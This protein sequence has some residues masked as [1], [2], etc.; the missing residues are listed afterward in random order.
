MNTN[1]NPLT[2]YTAKL[3]VK[4]ILCALDKHVTQRFV[5]FT[6]TMRFRQERA[7]GVLNIRFPH[8][9]HKQTHKT[10]VGGTQAFLTY[11]VM[12]NIHSSIRTQRNVI[13][14]AQGGKAL[15]TE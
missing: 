15:G 7:T 13:A 6:L 2:Y 8:P 10:S 1:N 14:P 3:T 9:S 11:K 4:S 12:K 5:I